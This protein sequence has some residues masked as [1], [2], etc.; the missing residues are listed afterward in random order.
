MARS[1]KG[2]GQQLNLLKKVAFTTNIPP[3]SLY[4]RGQACYWLL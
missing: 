4:A 2:S 1:S 3:F